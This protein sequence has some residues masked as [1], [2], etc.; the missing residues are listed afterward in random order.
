MPRIDNPTDDDIRIADGVILMDQARA[1]REAVGPM[2]PGRISLDGKPTRDAGNLLFIPVDSE[3]EAA[4]QHWR[5]RVEQLRDNR[6]R[7]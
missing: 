4:V 2:K 3:D 5:E 7:K 6:P 1:W